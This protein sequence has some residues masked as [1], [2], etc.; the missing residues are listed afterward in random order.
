MSAGSRPSD[1][2]LLVFIVT[3]YSRSLRREM[4]YRSYSFL[5]VDVDVTEKR[6]AAVEMIRWARMERMSFYAILV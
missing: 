6:L 1:R 5:G 2:C 3:N 4:R